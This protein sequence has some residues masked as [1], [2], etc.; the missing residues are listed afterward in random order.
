MKKNIGPKPALYPVLFEMPI[1]TYLAT[2]EKIADCL[3]FVKA[4]KGERFSAGAGEEAAAWAE[5]LEL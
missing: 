5:S 4:R 2:G 3:S 1:Y